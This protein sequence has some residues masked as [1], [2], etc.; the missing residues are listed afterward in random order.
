M[1]IGDIRNKIAEICEKYPEETFHL[2]IS[3]TELEICIIHLEAIGKINKRIGYS[4]DQHELAL[5]ELRRIR[6]ERQQTI[7]FNYNEKL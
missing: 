6:K 5:S 4:D 2:Y 7:E 1:E 3:P